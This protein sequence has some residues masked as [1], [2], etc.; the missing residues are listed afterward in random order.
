MTLTAV[1]I[2][3]ALLTACAGSSDPPV[4]QV[5]D[6]SISQATFRHWVK[7]FGYDDYVKIVGG[8]APLGL[9]SEPADDKACVAAAGQIPLVPGAKHRLSSVQLLLKCRQLH[10]AVKEQTLQIL[11][12]ELWRSVEGRELGTSVSES[13]VSKL[14]RQ[15]ISELPSPDAFTRY[16]AERHWSIADERFT[17]KRELLVSNYGAKIRKQAA[18]LGGGLP[19]TAQLV[20]QSFRRWSARTDCKAGYTALQCKQ[21]HGEPNTT[22][23]SAAELLEEL[24]GRS[25]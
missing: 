9:I 6:Q 8:R 12:P 22:A 21:R 14:L 11:I 4:V 5:G 1:T 13:E 15:V 17:L 10:A 23:P 3:A 7:L 20:Q 16:L 19:T 18:E 2:S 25:S 24:S